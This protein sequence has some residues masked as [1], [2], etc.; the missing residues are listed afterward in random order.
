M[1]RNLLAHAEE[2][3]PGQRYLI[4]HSA[5]SGKTHCIAW[6][7]Y[8]LVELQQNR[9]RQVGF[10]SVIVV[11]DRRV[12][13]RQ[14]KD[15]GQFAEIKNFVAHAKKA[16]ELRDLIRDRKRI[17]TTTVQKFP[18]VADGIGSDHGDRTFAV[19]IDEAHSS[20]AVAVRAL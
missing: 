10:D 17:I 14:T 3:G 4:Q 18:Y 7:G 11:T 8:Q 2:M 15:I 1:V 20:R 19:V 12:L 9:G 16:A 13:D 5:G 6:L